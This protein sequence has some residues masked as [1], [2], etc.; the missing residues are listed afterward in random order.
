MGLEIF[1]LKSLQH[2]SE[3][4]TNDELCRLLRRNAAGHHV[5]ELVLIEFSRGRPV[6]AADVIGKDFQARHGVRLGLITQ[7]QVPDL[8]VGVGFVGGFLD[9]DQACEDGP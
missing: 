3:E 6:R 8:L 7:H 5:E 4:A 2:S 9:L 1:I